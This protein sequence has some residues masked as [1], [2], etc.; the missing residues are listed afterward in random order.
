[1]KINK[2]LKTEYYAPHQSIMN[3]YVS[4]YLEIAFELISE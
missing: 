1:M 3:K 2:A 4:T